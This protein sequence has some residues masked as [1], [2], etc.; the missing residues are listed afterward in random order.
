M[1]VIRMLPLEIKG[2]MSRLFQLGLIV[3]VALSGGLFVLMRPSVTWFAAATTAGMLLTLGLAVGDIRQVLL[4]ALA[5]LIPFYIHKG[6]F[7]REG[8]GGILSLNVAVIDIILL[9]LAFLCL[10][11]MSVDKRRKVYVYPSIMMPAAVWFTVSALSVPGT[12]D[13][14]LGLFQLVM[15][16]KVLLLYLVIANQV[17]TPSDTKWIVVALISGLFL[18]A[19]LGLY[20]GWTGQPLGLWFLG[21]TRR[22]VLE[23]RLDIGSVARPQGTLGHPNGYAMY[24]EMLLPL[25]FVLLFAEIKPLYRSLIGL[26][27]CVGVVALVVSLSRGGWLSF[28]LSIGVILFFLTRHSVIRPQRALSALVWVALLLLIIA[29][30]FSG[31]VSSRLRSSD[32]GSFA[33]RFIFMRDAA[34]MTRDHPLLGVGLN[35]YALVMPRY[36]PGIVRRWGGGVTNVH[37]IFLLVVAEIGLVGL[38]AFLWSL[39]AFLKHGLGFV[40]Q[41]PEELPWL[42]GLAIFAGSLSVLLHSQADYALMATPSLATLF[43]FMAGWLMAISRGADGETRRGEV[44]K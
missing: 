35:N 9:L 10:A 34:A 22:E 29:F 8:H 44:E 14:T 41:A 17:R 1:M 25:A 28:G 3:M 13:P 27:F 2:W 32:E 5:F 23:F 16:S 4:T 43:W 40:R 26:T 30:A 6:L 24:L 39:A 7:V 33:S 19:I 38:A 15:I 37:N 18:Q 12:I 11:E 21:E 42:I 36:N 31:L 20:Q